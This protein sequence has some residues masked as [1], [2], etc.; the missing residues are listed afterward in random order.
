M[1]STKDFI[2]DKIAYWA[3][4][5][6]T[7]KKEGFLADVDISF[8]EKEF[9]DSLSSKE[10]TSAKKCRP[11]FL[12]VSSHDIKSMLVLLLIAAIFSAVAYGIIGYY[13]GH[14]EDDSG[15]FY[16]VE[17]EIHYH[18]TKDCTGIRDKS[19]IKTYTGRTGSGMKNEGFIPCYLCNPSLGAPTTYEKD[20]T[21]EY[22]F[23]ATT[24]VPTIIYFFVK[25]IN[26]NS[27]CEWVAKKQSKSQKA[28]KKD[29]ENTVVKKKKSMR[30]WKNFGL[31]FIALFI[32]NAIQV[33]LKA[34]GTQLGAIP[35][36]ILFAP[37]TIFLFNLWGGK[38]KETTSSEEN[39]KGHAEY[40]K[41]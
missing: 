18:C 21:I 8:S 25:C 36:L 31:S 38:K 15:K 22:I 39:E 9:A 26:W 3:L 14:F 4:K 10:S 7:N 19:R 24:F 28:L 35:A 40:V 30:F 17:G 16:A 13:T 27:S 37:F 1:Q 11:N 12:F 41:K 34:N 23:I 6:K 33:A 2:L 32:P 20:Y 5:H 29:S